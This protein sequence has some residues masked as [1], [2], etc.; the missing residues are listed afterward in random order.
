MK[1]KVYFQKDL[2]TKQLVSEIDANIKSM[3]A[4]KLHLGEPGNK[5]A[6]TPSQVRPFTDILDGLGIGFFLYDSPVI[7]GGLR[8]NPDSY[9]RYAIDKGWGK[10]GKIQIDESFIVVKGNHMDYEVCNALTNAQSVLVISHFKGH[11][12]SGFGGAVKN[13]GI[14]HSSYQ[15]SLLILL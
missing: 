2:D 3:A 14:I 6:L 4:V 8:S 5:T 7:Y 10:L 11:V 12:C 1:P 15:F 9:K 13:L